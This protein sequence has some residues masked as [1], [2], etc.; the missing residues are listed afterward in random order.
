V[1]DK[2]GKT[3]NE[4]TEL[5]TERTESSKTFD[6]GDGTRTLSTIVGIQHYKEDY[7]DKE[8]PW[9]DVD[10]NP[11]L[12][13]TDYVEYSHLPHITRIYKNKTGY[14]IISRKT[15]Q[16]FVV[17]LDSVEKGKTIKIEDTEDFNTEFEIGIGGVRLWKNIKT[18]KAPK[19]FKWKIIGEDDR[20]DGGLCFNEDTEAFSLT[21]KTKK[22]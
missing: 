4:V 10:T 1:A 3:Q 21:D 2:K 13:T 6:N 7:G 9:K 5:L 12:E 18:D 15:G 19:E 16:K 17:E 14:E 11:T 22:V 8:E 20:S